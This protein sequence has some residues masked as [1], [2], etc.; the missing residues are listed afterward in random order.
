MGPSSSIRRPRM[1]AS[2]QSSD[3]NSTSP[4]AA[5]TT[6]TR[7]TPRGRTSTSSCWPRTPKAT[8][9]SCRLSQRPTPKGSTT[10]R[11]STWSCCN[12]TTRA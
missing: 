10:D 12:N 5:A 6:E 9:T 1:P 2:N 3:A 8:R 4:R 11:A 7:P